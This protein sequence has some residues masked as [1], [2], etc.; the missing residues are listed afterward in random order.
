MIISAFEHQMLIHLIRATVQTRGTQYPNPAVGA[1]VIREG[2]IISEAYHCSHG[3][4]HAEVLALAQAKGRTDGAT[5]L[6]TLEPCTHHGKT[7]PCVDAIINH[8][9][10]RVVWAMDD[11]NPKTS[12]K[13]QAILNQHG[14]E[15]AAN[16][17][18]EEAIQ[19]C[20][21]FHA[22][23]AKKRPY[24]Y[25]KAA[26]SLDGMIA[27]N[28][29]GLTYISSNESLNVVQHL[30][31]WVQAIV[32]G[33]H[34]IAIDQPRLSIRLDRKGDIQPMI[35]ILDP[36]NKVDVDWVK[37]ALALGRTIYLF[38]SAPVAWTHDQLLV[39]TS[40]T[41]NKKHNWAHVFTMLHQQGI[42]GVLVEGGGR[43]FSSILSAGYFD[44]LWV[45]KVPKVLGQA[46][47]PFYPSD[48]AM[49]LTVEPRDIQAYGDDVVMAYK[50]RHDFSL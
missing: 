23:Y 12:Q 39:D 2:Q 17:L 50:N 8:G 45:T 7:P 3:S 4:H 18:S 31:T 42:Q 10:K 37:R 6:I 47:V 25:V 30:R 48:H 13:A 38:R 1:M 33:A 26:I 16:G 44:E 15:V 35:V 9:I 29:T 24:V 40:L 36:N 21:E 5:L 11:P 32:V 28:R 19:C 43:I 46:G 20:P 41:K 34:T 27:P 14:I 22:F 49:D